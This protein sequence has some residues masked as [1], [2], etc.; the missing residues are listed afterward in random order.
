[1]SR[2]CWTMLGPRLV[3]LTLASVP[4]LLGVLGCEEPD[5]AEISACEGIDIEGLSCDT[6]AQ[7]YEDSTSMGDSNCYKEYCLACG[8]LCELEDGSDGPSS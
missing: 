1:M 3:G 8:T 5:V 4:L 6:A 7:M 2:A